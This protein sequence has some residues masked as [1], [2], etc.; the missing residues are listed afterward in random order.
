MKH[1]SDHSASNHKIQVIQRIYE[2]Q[3]SSDSAGMAVLVSALRDSRRLILARPG[4]ESLWYHRRCI[5]ETML[6]KVSEWQWQFP[7]IDSAVVRRFTESVNKLVI[8]ITDADA[9]ES[10]LGEF[11]STITNSIAEGKDERL[12]SFI[13][14]FF[15]S[16]AAF[17]SRVSV[18]E[19][20]WDQHSQLRHMQSY[21]GFVCSRVRATLSIYF[22]MGVYILLTCDHVQTSGRL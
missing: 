19:V 3:K 11:C 18:G 20:V 7:A 14:A 22:T 13:T 8:D 10:S 12:I 6:S 5:V 21:F 4:H 17:I 9:V 2:M 1:I 15:E 16:E